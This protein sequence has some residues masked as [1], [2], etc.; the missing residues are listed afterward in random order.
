MMNK[1][2]RTKRPYRRPW[3]LTALLGWFANVVGCRDQVVESRV[4]GGHFLNPNH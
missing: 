3:L 1:T 4:W 2:L